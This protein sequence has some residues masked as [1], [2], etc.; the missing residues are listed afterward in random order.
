MSSYFTFQYT[1]MD[2]IE[3]H[4]TFF[5]FVNMDTTMK[6]CHDLLNISVINKIGLQKHKLTIGSKSGIPQ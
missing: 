4:T 5:I 3:T 2:A 1:N 6:Q